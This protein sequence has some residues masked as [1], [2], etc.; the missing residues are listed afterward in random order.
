MVCEVRKMRKRTGVNLTTIPINHI[1]YLAK[2]FLQ[3][4]TFKE[5]KRVVL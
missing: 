3:R 4:K 2:N 5:T 1:F